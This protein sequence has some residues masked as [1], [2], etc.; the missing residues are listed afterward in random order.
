VFGGADEQPVQTDFGAT[1]CPIRRQNGV[2]GFGTAADEGNQLRLRTDQRGDGPAGFLD[3]C[4]CNTPLD[5]HRGRIT[6]RIES[7]S[8]RGACFWPQRGGGV[9]VEVGA[10]HETPPARLD[11]E[12]GGV[13]AV[14]AFRPVRLVGAGRGADYP[15]I[16]R[17]L[18]S[19]GDVE[20]LGRQ[21]APEKLA[22]R[23]GPAR[24][25]LPKRQSSKAVTSLADSMIWSRTTRSSGIVGV[26]V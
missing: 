21:P 25:L 7:G 14:R 17:L 5:M 3:Q 12:L 20:T 19:L 16:L 8:C 18:S 1:G 6:E 24:I 10:L 2:V 11:P 4:A 9:V 13:D 22:D 26:P 23:R 15:I